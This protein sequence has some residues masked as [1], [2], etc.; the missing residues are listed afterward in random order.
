[1][2]FL[3]TAA[4]ALSL[5][6]S[7]PV[8]AGTD[9]VDVRSMVG[10]GIV[11]SNVASPSSRTAIVSVYKNSHA[12][13]AQITCRWGDIEKQDPRSSYDWSALD[14]DQMMEFS[15]TKI[16]SI[17]LSCPWAEK[18]KQ[19][20]PNGYWVVAEKFVR[21]LTK[22][23]NELGIKYFHIAGSEYNRLNRTD[24]PV[25]VVEP[26]A[27]L[28]P[29]IKSVNKG[30]VVIGGNLYGGADEDVQ[31]L[32]RAG[33]KGCFDVLEIHPYTD[34]PELGVD[35]DQ[36]ISAHQVM[37]RNGDGDKQIFV[38]EGWGPKSVDGAADQNG[39][40]NIL[41]NYLVNGYRKLSTSDGNYDPSWVLGALF[42]SMSD[43]EI[44]PSYK[45]HAKK[46]DE[47]GDGKI[48]Y[49]L[50]DGYRLPADTNIDRT[51]FNSGLCDINGNPKGDL[52]DLLGTNLK[53]EMEGSVSGS[54][55]ALTYLPGIPYKLTIEVYNVMDEPVEAPSIALQAD[56]PSVLIKDDGGTLPS[57][58]NGTTRIKH[59]F[60]VTIPDELAG[61]QV[62]FTGKLSFKWKGGAYCISNRTE[63]GTSKVVE[64]NVMPSSL[65]MPGTAQFGISIINHNQE[66]IEAHI[67]FDLPDGV[68]ISPAS[69]D[70]KIDPLGLETFTFSTA[71]APG[72]KTGRNP[73]KVLMDGKPV[74]TFDIV[75][76]AVANKQ[77]IKVD[78]SLG[79][80]KSASIPFG[81]E[82]KSTA[83]FAYDDKA[84][85][86]G[87]E[88]DDPVHMQPYSGL[89]IWRGDSVRVAIDPL[90]DG[91]LTPSGGYRDD[92]H[93][94]VFATD[95]TNQ[96]ASRLFGKPRASSARVICSISNDKKTVYE[97]AIP[98]S[99]VA[100]FVPVGEKMFAVSILVNDIGSGLKQSVWGGGIAG[101]K[102]P[103]EFLPVKM[104]Q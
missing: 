7:G 49:I 20:D 31:A 9:H 71:L 6:F 73:A 87:V 29:V 12:T 36:I 85:Y 27:H 47:D 10:A 72:L 102:N 50:V 26:L 81:T 77:Q 15:R 82:P 97:I 60:T 83:R 43:Y 64:S 80:W 79:E 44:G 61:S 94:F 8:M 90:M 58:L 30:N 78:G 59:D 18:L 95:G 17:D 42:N 53:I 5:L 19:Q 93:E 91:A 99:E 21:E 24:W 33:I 84:F 63:M 14:S 89:E 1:M 75:A 103:D 48:D 74:K 55:T 40:L 16:I 51:L 88:T 76:P 98:W 66:K 45:D 37:K 96:A 70:T 32:Y 69:A 13:C 65:V 62:C 2:P 22:H 38:G 3:L 46:I 54:G 11:A 68:R 4:T 67:A 104:A 100:P 35:I 86:I 34:K 41:R 25:L 101:K 52:L 39:E 57:V 23:C 92:D 28:Y 56:N